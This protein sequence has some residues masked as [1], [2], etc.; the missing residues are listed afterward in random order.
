M[1]V[2]VIK[3]SQAIL[4]NPYSLEP[5]F[6]FSPVIQAFLMKKIKLHWQILIALCLGVATGLLLG[7][8]G[9][10][11]APLGTIFLNALKMIIVPL[12]ITSIVTGVSNIDDTVNI[13]RLGLKTFFYYLST[14]LFAILTGL[15]L[16][17]LFE[18]GVNA[19]MGLQTPAEEITKAIEENYSGSAGE[20]LLNLL[21][22][23]VPINPF[24]AMVEGEMLQVIVFCLL[25]GYF[26]TKTAE[27]YRT[28]M[29]NFFRAGFA[30]MM[31]LTHFII[32]FA[33][34]GIFGLVT[35]IVATTGLAAFKG[36][37]IYALTVFTGLVVHGA[38]TLPLLLWLG[39]RGVSPIKHLKAMTAA[40][41]TAFSTSSSSATLPLTMK[42]VE[43]NDGVSTKVSSFVLPLGATM[44]MDGTALYECVAAMFIAQ[45]YGIQLGFEQQFLIVIT[46]LLVSIGAAG[47]P[48]AGIVMMS[49]ILKAA[50]LPLEGVGLILTVDRILDMCRT[51]VNVWSDSCGAVI[52]A[53]TEG[54]DLQV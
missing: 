50:G 44:N 20:T 23:M 34:L 27:P 2:I 53:R 33:P 36:L 5:E 47:I 19:A 6:Y 12:I 18:P 10:I 48:M 13:G 3:D 1:P 32:L 22:R 46:A 28:T 21:I 14:S 37:G 26:I 4:A 54:E 51:T 49:V 8:K 7:E 16:V 9:L 38:I 30:V 24:R 15:T 40:L 52:I 17:N 29:N 11:F 42:S 43:E 39:G 45:A 25:F 41:L 31:K 35:K